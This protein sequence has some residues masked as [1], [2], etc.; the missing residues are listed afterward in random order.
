M[1]AS[2]HAAGS[3]VWVQV[4]VKA[5]TDTSVTVDLS[6][7]PPGATAIAIRY[8]WGN[9]DSDS[10]CI[11]AGPTEPCVPASC[12]L[13]DP[14]STLPANPFIAKIDSG[15]CKCIPPQVCDE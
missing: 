6:K 15:K 5:S 4:D 10:C 1:N 13:W 14:K 12:P 11:P 7:L 8:A 2:T 9:D 3:S